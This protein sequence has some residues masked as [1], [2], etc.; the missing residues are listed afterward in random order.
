MAGIQVAGIGSGL[1]VNSIVN[2]L[3]A[4]DSAP[5]KALGNKA[6][7]IQGNIGNIGA[8]KTA[9]GNFQNALQGLS[10]TTAATSLLGLQAGSSDASIA[11]G[12]I[13]GSAN[14][15]DYAVNVTTLAASQ[16]IVSTSTQLS[17]S[18]PLGGGE[19]SL[20]LGAITNGTLDP[21]TGQYSGATF[22]PS[23]ATPVKITIP[24]GSTLTQIANSINGANAGVRA[25]VVYD[26][27]NY[28]LTLASTQPGAK[29]SIQM[30]ATGDAALQSLVSYDPAGSQ[31]FKQTA[32]ASDLN[33]T[34]N[35]IPLTSSSN[36]LA[37][38]IDGITLNVL[39]VGSATVKVSQSVSAVA[40]SMNA[41]V[42]AWNSLN[43]LSK[44]LTGYDPATKVAGD[45]QSDS[46]S[47]GALGQLRS[48]FFGSSFN[49]ANPSYKTLMSVG[50]SVDSKGVASIDNTK[51]AA[52]LKAD[53]QAVQKLFSLAGGN[54][55]KAAN[56]Q[57]TALTG[58]GGFQARIDSLN[59][60][61]RTISKQ[62]T[63]MQA[64]LDASKKNLLAQFS[65]LD[66]MVSKFN[67]VS[68]YLTQNFAAASSSKS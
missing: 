23:S 12:S 54:A 57:L 18:A 14:N 59:S 11:T 37:G 19:I 13:T 40:S 64:R 2:Q 20:S 27:K 16:S 65:S 25:G 9:Y 58:T 22:T 67:N 32:A 36:S 56:A 63:S 41:M 24:A 53:P 6:Q 45:L 42:T 66:S 30:S 48:S 33:A 47:S 31:S 62:Q 28:L 8:L 1:D 15:G 39:K 43:A 38:N 3:I 7:K 4:A 5:L 17:S 10:S 29:S 49:G 26:G 44:N 46:L 34:V 50:V 51:L 55:G 61:L 35:G 68:T 60:Q 21:A 52:A